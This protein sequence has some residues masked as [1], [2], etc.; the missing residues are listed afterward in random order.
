MMKRAL[1]LPHHAKT[2]TYLLHIDFQHSRNCIRQYRYF[3]RMDFNFKAQC[4]FDFHSCLL[5]HARRH[6]WCGDD[7]P[8]GWMVSTPTG[9]TGLPRWML[10]AP[11]VNRWG[12]FPLFIRK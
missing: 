5:C 10:T 11:G 6:G 8:D 3:S 1:T 4:E 7:H 2:G 12:P 9:G